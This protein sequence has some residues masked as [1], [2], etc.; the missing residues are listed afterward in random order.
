MKNVLLFL[1]LIL[2]FTSGI[3]A[4]CTI[5]NSSFETWKTDSIPTFTDTMVINHPEG[6]TPA[7]S[8][9]FGMFSGLKPGVMEISSGAQHGSKAVQLFADSTGEYTDGGDIL[10][11]FACSS[12]PASLEGYFKLEGISATDTAIIMIAAIDYSTG[13]PDTIGMGISY[14]TQEKTAWTSFSVPVTYKKSGAD[15]VLIYILFFT[16]TTGSAKAFSIDNLSFQTSSLTDNA[17]TIS[18]V[19]LYPNPNQGVL[20]TQASPNT[21]IRIYN[22]L[23][24]LVY[25]GTQ[26]DQTS[27]HQIGFLPSGIYYVHFS[28][29]ELIKAEK[30]IIS[31]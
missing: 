4:Q 9:L 24:S 22:A 1:A 28:N 23:G 19:L 18:E 8:L 20:Y 26:F 11:Q 2:L 16:E 10:T 6:W 29:N 5:P 13:N 21:D 27:S 12:D 30:L 15:S 17:Q 7:L 25:A 14:F 3:Q 31:K